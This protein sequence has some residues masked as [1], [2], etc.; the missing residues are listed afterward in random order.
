MTG[1]LLV[2]LFLIIVSAL[3]DREKTLNGL[4]K[5]AAMFVNILPTFLAILILVAVVLYLFPPEAIREHLGREQ[6]WRGLLIGSGIGSVA[7]LPAF[8]AYPLASTL[9]M[10]G[11]G[12][13]TV[14]AFINTLMMVG[15]ITLPVEFRYLGKKAAIL[16]NLLS[17]VGSVTVALLMELAYEWIW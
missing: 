15:V 1:F 11:A 10:Q 4:K 2:G 14:G 8:I 6:G 7:L 9:L 3:R 5:G 12:I 16:R 13:L 17:L